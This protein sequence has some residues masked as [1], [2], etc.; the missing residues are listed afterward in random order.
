MTDDERME[1]LV[2][3]TQQDKSYA[4]DAIYYLEF[5]HKRFVIGCSR[6]DKLI[7]GRIWDDVRDTSFYQPEETIVT[8]ERQQDIVAVLRQVKSVIG[9]RLFDVLVMFYI[10]LLSMDEI[11]EILGTYRMKIWRIINTEIP[12]KLSST[13]L[14]ELAAEAL[15]KPAA[16][17]MQPALNGR[18]P[19]EIWREYPQG[20]KHWKGTYITV[21]PK[22]YLLDYFKDCFGDAKT[23][24]CFCT[25]RL[26]K[27]LCKAKSVTK[28]AA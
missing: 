13:N 20:G 3:R 11:A 4:G 18:F 9:Q 7:K 14:R 26:G 15:E 25:N 8:E 28:E 22:C 10:K 17:T 1:Y 16:K 12:K 24:C 21:R 5:L 27:N 2:N 23:V 19:Y 6:H